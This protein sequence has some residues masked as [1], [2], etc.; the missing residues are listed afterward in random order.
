MIFSADD[1]EYDDD[2]N[3]NNDDDFKHDY[4]NKVAQYFP[5]LQ[6]SL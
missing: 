1:D 4:E 2:D 3:E 5:S 6:S